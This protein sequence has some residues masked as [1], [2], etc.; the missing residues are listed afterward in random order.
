MARILHFPGIGII[1]TVFVVLAVIYSS[2]TPIFEASD[3]V[4]HYAV[5]QHIADTGELPVQQP[6]VKTQWEQEGSQPPLYYLLVS[7]V[8]R[9]I[10]TR[11]AAERMTRNP[12]AAPGNP[13]LDANRNLV[14]HSPA[15]DFPWRNITLVVHLIRFLSILMGAGTIVL[16]YSIA[17]RIFPDKSSVPIGTAAL[18]AFNPMFIF[19]SASVNNDNLTILLTSLALYLSVLCWY[20]P[21]GRVDRSGWWRRLWLGVVLG[22]AALSKISGLTLLPIVALILT[23]R[24][25]RRR[26][27]R[28]WIF[29]GMLVALPVMLIAAWWYARNLQLYGELFG[30]DT[31]VSIAGPRT[32]ALIDLVPE[33]DGFRYSY[34]ALFGAV[35]IV[36]FPLAYVVFDLFTLLAIIGCGLWLLRN[37][38]TDRFVLMII[39]AGYV[40]IVFIGVVR[41]TMM[42]PA[43]QGRLMFPAISAISLLLWLGWETTLD[44]R[45]RNLDFHKL[46]WGMPIFMLAVAVIVP[47]RDIAPTYAGPQMITE[48][49]LPSDL[50]RLD[51]DYGDQLRLI[52]YRL[53]A[54]LARSDS[55]E[56][57]LYWQCLMPISADYSVFAIVYGRA[58]RELGKRDAYPYHGLYATRQCQPGQIF[59][60]PYRIPIE[61]S[62]AFKPTVLRAQIGLRDGQTGIELTPTAGSK[63]LSAV[64]LEVGKLID[65]LPHEQYATVDYRLGDHIHLQDARINR[66]GDAPYLATTWTTTSTPPEAYTI[67]VHILDANGNVIGQADGPPSGGNYPTDW[68]SPGETIVEMRPLPLPPEADRVTIGLYRLGDQTRLPVLDA[69]GQRVPN[70]EIVLPAQP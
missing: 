59:A 46:R 69:T 10:D 55:A 25:L 47:F 3:E 50:K 64:M 18:I 70:D 21:P 12:H 61:A 67:F 35:N 30:L 66:Q 41:W 4:S 33:F 34:W 2:A 32:M 62:G 60:D 63:P 26:D 16:S 19:I 37:R 56:F 8:A 9:V 68:W 28:G 27:W 7:A 54:P 6:G 38:W 58:L 43:S 5:V 22:G 24:H 48:Q 11:D 44:F 14:I 17:R 29:S 51:V 39:L 65:T 36:T 23:V 20:E 13:S 31:M 52:G 1:V 57:T 42:T 15:E 49:Q 45:F 53:A 40:L